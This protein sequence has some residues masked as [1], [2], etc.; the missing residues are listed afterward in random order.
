[1]DSDSLRNLKMYEL[2]EMAAGLF[3]RSEQ[4]RKQILA[5]CDELER[6]GTNEAEA[7]WTELWERLNSKQLRS[8]GHAPAA[9]LAQHPPTAPSNSTLPPIAPAAPT[10]LPSNPP[11]PAVKDHDLHWLQIMYFGVLAGCIGITVLFAYDRLGWVIVLWFVLLGFTEEIFDWA[12]AIVRLKSPL[13]VR[14]ERRLAEQKKRDDAAAERQAAFEATRAAREAQI[15]EYAT[16]R[17][18]W[19]GQYRQYLNSPSWKR[20]RNRVM[21]RDGWT[22]QRCGSRA[23]EVHHVKY[24]KAHGRGDFSKQP[25]NNMIALCKACHQ[26]AHR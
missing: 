7:L 20:V 26:K 14:S 22:C 2:R 9:A 10:V 3:P 4:E 15:Q 12:R 21:K 24:T 8:V 13:E 23:Q 25:M 16:E 11:A 6:R 17:N 1:M 18:S 5:L 19:R